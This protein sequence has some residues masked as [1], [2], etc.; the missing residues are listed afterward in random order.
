MQAELKGSG[1][2]TEKDKRW[3]ANLLPAKGEKQ[4]QAVGNIS[5]WNANAN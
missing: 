3:Q 1:I 2:Y 5:P 4:H